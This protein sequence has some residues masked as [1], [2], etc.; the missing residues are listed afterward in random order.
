MSAQFIEKDGLVQFAVIPMD[1]YEKLVAAYEDLVDVAA[2]DAAVEE[3]RD[4]E[5]ELIPADIAERLV[6]G[7]ESHIKIWR[8]YRGLTQGQLS[9]MADCTQAYVAMLESGER[10]G[11]VNVVSAIARALNVGIDDL[12][13][14]TPA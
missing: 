6:L 7:N 12:V 1:E 4:S 3:L 8:K 11:K 2:F 10:E 5:D 9:E 14:N 13:Q